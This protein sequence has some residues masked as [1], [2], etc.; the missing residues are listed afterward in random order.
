[1]PVVEVGVTRY[2][3]VPDVALLGFK[4]TSLIVP[5][6]P[7]LAPVIPPVIVPTVHVKLLGALEVNAMLVFVLL[8]MLFVAAFVTTGLGYTVTVIV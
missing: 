7:G 3:T 8:Q 6:A 2:S 4:S 5:T 1:V